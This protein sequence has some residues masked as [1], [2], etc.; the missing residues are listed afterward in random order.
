MLVVYIQSVPSFPDS[1][2]GRW[3]P[4]L[5]LPGWGVR[6]FCELH[7]RKGFQCTQRCASTGEANFGFELDTA[8]ASLIWCWQQSCTWRPPEVLPAST[9]RLVAL[10]EHCIRER[11]VS[12]LYFGSIGKWMQREINGPAAVR[13]HRSSAIKQHRTQSTSI[14]GL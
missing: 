7:Q 1:C 4:Q 3:T 11:K 2:R 5:N 6:A 13:Q 10:A 12:I 9:C 14:P 8:M